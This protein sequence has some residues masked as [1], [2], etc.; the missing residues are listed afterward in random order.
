[1]VGLLPL[2]AVEVLD[3]AVFARI[4]DFS[5]CMRWFLTCRPHLVQLA[6]AEPVSAE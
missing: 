3:A 2:L 1:M 5:A 4:P 6:L